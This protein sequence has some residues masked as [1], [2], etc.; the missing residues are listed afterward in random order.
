M[1]DRPGIIPL[2]PIADDLLAELRS[3]TLA[4]SMYDWTWAHSGTE[5]HEAA[6]EYF[7]ESVRQS[8]VTDLEL[9]VFEDDGGETLTVAYTGNGPTS[10]ANAR[11]I[12]AAQPINVIRLLD[13]IERL[14]RD[15]SAFPRQQ[16]CPHCGVPM[17]AST[18]AHTAPEGDRPA[19][20]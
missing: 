8:D 11:F 9:V 12:C 10:E 6:V 13:E 5:T 16:P 4:A 20:A 18:P 3:I 19:L 7:T 2:G 17:I 14:R 15:A 1:S